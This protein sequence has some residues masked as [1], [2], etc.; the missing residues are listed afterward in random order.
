MILQ[1]LV[2]LALAQ[3]PLPPGVPVPVPSNDDAVARAFAVLSDPSPTAAQSAIGILQT[4]LQAD[5]GSSVARVNLGLALQRTGDLAGAAREYQAVTVSDPGC[6]AAWALLGWTKAIQGDPVGAE[7]TWRDGVRAAPSDMTVRAA[8]ANGLRDWKRSA[9]AVDVAKE[10]LRIDTRSVEIYT[11]LGQAYLD[12]GQLQLAK[13]VFQKALRDTDG[14][15]K[16]DLPGADGSADLHCALGWTWFQLGDT[17]TAQTELEK[18]VKFDPQLVTALIYLSR[19]YLD[20]HNYADTV[21]LLERA[22]A[23]APGNHA[24]WMNLGLAY[25]GAGKLAEA[26][27]TYQKAL[28]IDPAVPDPHFNLAVLMGDYEKNYPG[29]IAEYRAYIDAGGA[30]T[31]L[32]ESY[33]EAVEKEQKTQDKRKKADEDRKRRE[34]ERKRREEEKARE[35]PAPA[36]E[37]VP[38]PDEAP[39]PVPPGGEPVPEPAPEVVPPPED[40]PAPLPPP[41]PEPVPPA[42]DPEP[43]PGSPWGEPK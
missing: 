17:Y 15:G 2:S 33:I 1:L 18:A 19:L 28:T 7:S 40:V 21:P 8:L 42:P 12:Q 27:A 41:S 24:V 30:E 25:R 35:V 29:A 31:L 20:Q 32:A 14:D 16:S 3:E 26:K 6:G 37:V 38:P 23:Q 4:A 36:P 22:S 11:A 39:T 13:F 10:A 9:E 43:T 5:P 34:E